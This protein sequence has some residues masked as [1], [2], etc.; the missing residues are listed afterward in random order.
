MK[1]VLVTGGA[2]YIG[3]HTTQKL[4][5]A[6]YKVV[7]I[8]NLTTGF[9][10]A[11]PAGAE[12]VKGDVRAS[13]FVVEVMKKF[14]VEAVIHFAAK[15]VVPESIE[16]PAEYHDNNVGGMISMLNA[17]QM[18]GISKFVFSSTAAV[19]GEPSSEHLISEIAIPKPLNPYGA[20]KLESE[21]L[22]K[23]ARAIR[24]V[25]LRYFNVAGAA[26]DGSNGQRTKGATHLVKVACEAACGKRPSVSIFGTD[27]P[28]KDGTG[29]RDFIYVEDLADLHILALKYLENGGETDT[30]NC[31]YG[32]GTSVRDVLKTVQMVSG[33]DFTIEE[34][35][36]R[37]GD[38]AQV[39]ADPSKIKKAF[40]WQPRHHDLELICRTSYDWE[41]KSLNNVRS[42]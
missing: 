32:K 34:R 41:K 30:F 19:Y 15:L 2:G 3:S 22:L 12:F 18:A 16:K 20:T 26:L 24:S 13:D 21:S 37:P 1:S 5:T 42:N 28:T 39:V 6:G 33:S 23:K 14:K 40:Q 27:Y 36:R 31:G 25:I 4:L 7:V 9:Q 8:D 17:C 38:S 10:E 35:E 29:V 11:V